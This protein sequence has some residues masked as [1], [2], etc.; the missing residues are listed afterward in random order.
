[1][2][3]LGR[4]SSLLTWQQPSHPPLQRPSAAMATLVPVRMKYC[5]LCGLPE[6]FCEYNTEVPH[7]SRAASAQDAPPPAAGGASSA[8]AA[9]EQAVASLSLGDAEGG[10]A[11]GVRG[12]RGGTRSERSP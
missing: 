12:V 7:P 11:A 8:A 9:A 6:E 2:G 3:T 5:A 1:M 4:L 10:A